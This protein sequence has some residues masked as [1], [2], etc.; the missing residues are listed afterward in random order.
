CDDVRVRQAVKAVA[1]DAFRP[2]CAWQRQTLRDG[3]HPSVESGVEARDLREIGEMGTHSVDAVESRGKVEWGE[4][5][6]GPDRGD[7]LRRE[8]LWRRMVRPALERPM[9]G[10]GGGGGGGGGARS[11]RDGG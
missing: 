9:A 11:V 4:R 6:Q 7:E 1:L 8:A 5:N 2:Q 3:G 10:G